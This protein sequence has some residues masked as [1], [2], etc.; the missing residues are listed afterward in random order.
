MLC[1]VFKPPDI[2]ADQGVFEDWRCAPPRL[3]P[4]DTRFGSEDD[5]CGASASDA[6]GRFLTRPL[7]APRSLAPGEVYAV[8]WCVAQDSAFNGSHRMHC[9]REFC[10]GQPA[11]ESRE[12]WGAESRDRDTAPREGR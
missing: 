9:L 12:G 5:E 1:A 10:C 11:P 6:T 8:M 3:A 2:C 4:S 7:D